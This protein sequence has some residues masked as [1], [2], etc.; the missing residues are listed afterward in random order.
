[1]QRQHF[2][3]LFL[4]LF[5]LMEWKYQ[6]EQV[7]FEQATEQKNKVEQAMTVAMDASSELLADVQDSQTEQTL[8]A[9]SEYFFRAL[10]LCMGM[11]EAEK[12]DELFF[13]VPILVVTQTEG[14]YLYSMQELRKSDGSMEYVRGW[15][16][17]IPYVYLNGE[18]E[19]RYF[20]DDIAKGEIEKKHEAIVTSLEEHITRGLNTFNLIAKQQ[21][22]AIH[23]QT[24]T[25]FDTFNSAL[26]YPAVIAV[27]QGWPFS[28]KGQK[29]YQNSMLSAAFLKQ[30]SYVCVEIPD[31]LEQPYVV[32]H[33]KDCDKIGEF[34]VLVEGYYTEEE[35][36]K[37]YG[38]FECPNCMGE[39]NTTV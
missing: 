20:L 26:K 5:L 19:Q 6:T 1:M 7:L 12:M 15:S 3:L 25:F 22:S 16:E 14:F 34:G 38:A 10:A 8:E 21:G 9:F 35:A 24:P 32:M 2:M 36:V 18:S 27:F 37:Q 23:F 17:C 11:E 39:D 33:R 13:Y 4:C 28:V 29:L 30:R 31:S